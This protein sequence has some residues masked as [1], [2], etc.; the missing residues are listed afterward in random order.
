MTKPIKK[1]AKLADTCKKCGESVMSTAYPS[2]KHSIDCEI[3]ELL[4]LIKEKQLKRIEPD[5]EVASLL[6]S[7]NSL[8]IHI[9]KFTLGSECGYMQAIYAPLW[10]HEG[11]TMYHCMRFDGMSLEEFLETLRPEPS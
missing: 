2:I 3:N 4:S 11:I 8:P 9:H 1:N 10:I 5:D 7:H 6:S